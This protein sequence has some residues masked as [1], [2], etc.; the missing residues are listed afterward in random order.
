VYTTVDVFEDFMTL[1]FYD[2][3]LFLSDSF[4]PFVTKISQA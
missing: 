4:T 1:D 2:I 3:R